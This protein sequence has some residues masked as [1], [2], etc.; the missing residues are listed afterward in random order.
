MTDKTTKGI[1][2]HKVAREL[3]LAQDRLVQHLK[4]QGFDLGKV[5]INTK[6][7][8][9]MYL[10]LLDAF[11]KEKAEAERHKRWEAQQR[12]LEEQMNE[13]DYEEDAPPAAE[14]KPEPTPVVEEI[15]APQPEI[16]AP[17]AP[18]VVH[19][20]VEAKAAE[21]KAIADKAVEE[22]KPEPVKPEPVAVEPPVIAPVVEPTP[23]PVVAPV[24]EPAVVEVTI[25][26]EVVEAKAP[27]PVE[28]V[29]EKQAES[30]EVVP[31][32]TPQVENKVE[33]PV[34]AVEVK[35][36]EAVAETEAK[37]PES[38]HQE[39][40]KPEA[41]Q[42]EA[43]HQEARHQETRKPEAKQQEAKQQ[44]TQKPEVKTPQGA[45]IEDSTESA[46]KEV[47]IPRSEMKTITA[48]RYVLEGPKVLGMVDLKQLKDAEP[49]QKRRKR[50]RKGKADDAPAPIEPKKL[51]ETMKEPT[52]PSGPK[53]DFKKQ[54]PAATSTSKKKTPVISQESV[55]QAITDT[56][57]VLQRQGTKERQGARDRRKL[58]RQTQAER[59]E[60]EQLQADEE[61]KIL[62]VLEF[63]SANELS[64][65]MDVSVTDVIRVCLELGMMVSINQ[66]LDADTITLI[67]EE[68][69]FEPEFLK[70]AS[71]EEIE[72]VEDSP[73]DLLPRAP[74]VTIMGHVDHG[75]TSLL[76]YI[77]RANVVSSEAGGIT[78]HIGA[79]AVKIATG[80]QI[81]FLDTPGHEAFTAMRARGAQVTD[82]VI[83]VVAADD[84]VMPQTIEAINHAKAAGVPIIV[85]I[86]KM[87]KEGLNTDRVLK[88]L[89]DY[90]VLVEQWGGDV[91]AEFISAKS[92]MNVDKLLEKI[93]LEAEVLDLK[94]NPNRNSV[95]TIIESRIDKGRGMV[96]TVLVQKGTLNV[97][98]VFV[99]GAFNGKV[100]AMY[101]E[102]E[103]KVKQVGPAQPALV[104]GFSGAPDVGDRFVVLN[105]EREAK[106][107]AGHRQQIQREQNMRQKKH[108]TLDEIGRRLALGQFKEL[109]IIIKADV[110][111]S[112]QALTDSLLK[113]STEE[114]QVRIIHSGVGAII[115]SDIMLA[116]ASDAVIIGFQV[117]PA[118]AKVKNMADQ[119][120]IDM[121]YYSVI[122]DAI[123]DVRD[124]LEG[125]LS[126]ELSEKTLGVAEIRE[127]FRV[128]K[129]GAV[130]GCMVTSG[131]ITRKDQIRLVRDG[132]VIY[133]GKIG[134]LR[135]FKDNVADV[136]TGF[137]C[138]IGVDGYNDIQE[139]DLIES[140]EVIQTRK[141]LR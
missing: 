118:N 122:Y 136:A 35:A 54:A 66:R 26:P 31:S 23:E 16:A 11:A 106:S 137:E 128:P 121:R 72:D 124:A 73:E 56:K 103:Q 61:A 91:Q 135:R 131:K 102:H 20:E 29:A 3:N 7:T 8:D 22:A 18:E 59:R 94:A 133:N 96:A 79:Y 139:G 13:D 140:Y 85:A 10:S 37:L 125:L 43:K 50:K 90:G 46:P 105:D 41:K 2:L 77:R 113:L 99:A 68:F 88:E 63:V 19:K 25:V 112:V 93:V 95:G 100:R 12:L 67:A 38:K 132:V 47:V 84:S 101:D 130:A 45:K 60:M 1:P 64:N 115:E 83:I 42:Q 71:S 76:D 21:D 30:A 52:A 28:P 82:V 134:S 74:V 70:D 36:P 49:G 127:V 17:V 48:D 97:G 114:V 51:A 4:G 53:K 24:V 14:V 119:E 117:R 111:G 80:H 138:G 108:I 120:Q 57:S 65:L 126:P 78:Q 104:V 109:N 44:E 58:K 81:T 32:P 86:N 107:I 39:A 62:R 40:K 123:A 141:K 15:A 75:K 55:Q 89:A 5:T 87:D 98:D 9:E 110:G 27:T 129:I 92:G 34:P 69:G 6:I 33:T 116:S